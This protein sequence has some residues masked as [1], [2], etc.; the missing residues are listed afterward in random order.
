[1]IGLVAGFLTRL[2]LLRVDYRQ[3]PSYPHAYV[4]HLAFGFI[5]AAVGAVSIPALVER[6]FTAVTFLV[7][8]ATQFR[9]IRSMERETLQALDATL[10]VPRGAD[11]I[12]G[13]ASVFEARNYLA[14]GVAMVSSGLTILTGWPGGI[15]G[16]IAGLIGAYA[17]RSGK[18]VGDIAEVR[19]AKVRF[20]GPALYVDDIYIM[21]VGLEKV[22]APLRQWAVG[23]TLHPRDPSSRDKLAHV[24]QRLAIL[25]DLTAALG[26]RQDVSAPEFTPMA[27]KDQE[28]GVIGLFAVPF[29]REFEAIRK[30]I[31]KVPLLESARRS[32]PKKFA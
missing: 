2:L 10:L 18:C 17:L 21:N 22:R 19:E 8:V 11:Y 15:A 25:H 5:A 29:T 6:E 30:V 27:R 14:M 9:E 24:G 26:N 28:S 3:Y 1:M 13:I 20:D 7:L 32:T 4:S 23:V 12:E 31:E 16:G